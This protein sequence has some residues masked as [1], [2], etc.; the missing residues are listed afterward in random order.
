MTS[1]LITIWENSN[2][3]AEQYR[4]ASA[5]YLMLVMLQFYPVIIDRGISATGHDKYVVYGINAIDKHYIY[6]LM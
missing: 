3:Y 2:V 5:L 4:C 6:Q 1:A